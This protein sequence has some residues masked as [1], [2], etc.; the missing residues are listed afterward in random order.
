MNLTA[1]RHGSDHIHSV[2][3]DEGSGTLVIR[4]QRGGSYSYAGVDEGT[5]LRL[6]S[7][8]SPGGFFRSEIKGRFRHRRL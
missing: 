8:P 1:P 7:A 4:F 6:L 5:Y 2:G 3:Y